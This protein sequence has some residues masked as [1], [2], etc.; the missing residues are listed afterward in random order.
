MPAEAVL[1]LPLVE[2][3]CD[4]PMLTGG[5]NETTAISANLSPSFWSV[6]RGKDIG[7]FEAAVTPGV[8]GAP[9]DKLFAGLPAL[10]VS[11]E[12]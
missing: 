11:L 9:L 12:S 10:A 1:L 8:P 6:D 2:D 4:G 7:R 3:C 5:T